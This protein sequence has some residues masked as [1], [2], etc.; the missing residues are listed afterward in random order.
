MKILIADDDFTARIILKDIL[1]NFGEC[2]AVVNGID[3][4]A[5]FEKAQNEEKPYDLICLDILM[6]IMDGQQALKKIRDIEKEK[7]STRNFAKIIMITV[8]DDSKNVFDA[9][10]E[11]GAT[12]YIVKPFALER[13]A[14][15]LTNFGL[16]N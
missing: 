9:C 16:I 11:N 4:I 1:S 6:P 12:S 14:Q 7:Y 10:Y 2:D 3:A 8:L 13:I 5:A 15:E